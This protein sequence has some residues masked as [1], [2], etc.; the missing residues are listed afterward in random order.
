MYSISSANPIHFTALWE[1]KAS[2]GVMCFTDVVSA[3]VIAKYRC[4]RH[5]QFDHMP[6]AKRDIDVTRGLRVQKPD[7]RRQQ[8]T[9]AGSAAEEKETS[10]TKN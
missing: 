6:N 10:S 3:D 4:R 2:A 5:D 9:S 7:G 1:D 8:P